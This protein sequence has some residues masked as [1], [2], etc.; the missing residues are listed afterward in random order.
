M[1]AGKKVTDKAKAKPTPTAIMFPSSRYGGES[2]K[3]RVNTPM[4]VVMD[5]TKIGATLVRKASATAASSA[6]ASSATAAAAA[7]AASSR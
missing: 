5:V 2:L 3:L 6:A 4:M 1:S 7:A